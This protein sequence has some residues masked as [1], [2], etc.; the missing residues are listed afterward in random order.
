MERGKRA[1]IFQ[2]VHSNDSKARF[3]DLSPPFCSCSPKCWHHLSSSSNKPPSSK[4]HLLH[5]VG[6]IEA[7]PWMVKY[8]LLP[9]MSRL[10]IC[11]Y[12]P[13]DVWRIEKVGGG[14]NTPS[15][16]IFP[17]F[18]S[19]LISHFHALDLIYSELRQKDMLYLCRIF[20]A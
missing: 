3:L 5:V 13:E 12:R 1:H 7:T 11:C 4:S 8:N 19:G 16:P 17:R 18:S 2:T 14:K 20:Y 6:G 10:E 15:S 9:L